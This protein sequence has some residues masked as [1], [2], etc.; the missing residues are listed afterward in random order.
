MPPIIPFYLK[1]IPSDLPYQMDIDDLSEW[2]KSCQEFERELRE[3]FTEA[4]LDD[5]VDLYEESFPPNRHDVAKLFEDAWANI[6]DDEFLNKDTEM[7]SI[8]IK[9]EFEKMVQES[10]SESE[11]DHLA[12]AE[13]VMS[14]E[15]MTG[16]DFHDAEFMEI[17]DLPIAELVK[18]LRGILE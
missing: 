3:F 6:I 7:S 13:L 11:Y 12:K 18:K 8:E 17:T 4:R 1:D 15:D 16:K 9:E 5:L 2:V 14:F 10:Y